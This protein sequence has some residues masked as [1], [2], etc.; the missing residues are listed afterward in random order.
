[1]YRKKTEDKL[2]MW[3]ITIKI[4]AKKT[5]PSTHVKFGNS[6]RL[7]PKLEFSH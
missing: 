1:M 6:H 5:E 2:S 3:N 7:L 4:D